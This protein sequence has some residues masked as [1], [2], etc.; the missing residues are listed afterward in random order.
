MTVVEPEAAAC[1]QASAR[2]GVPVVIPPGTPTRMAMLECHAPSR[3]AWRILE[4]AADAF[5]TVDED[6]RSVAAGGRAG[7]AHATPC[8]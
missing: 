3:A 5:P 1:V 2:A 8:R 6:D 7:P 4:R